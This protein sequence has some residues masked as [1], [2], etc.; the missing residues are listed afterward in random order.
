MEHSL[1]GQDVRIQQKA[2]ALNIGD[3]TV[4]SL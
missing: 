2:V 1:I 4:L 3:Q